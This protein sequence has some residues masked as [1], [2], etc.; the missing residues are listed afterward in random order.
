MRKSNKNESLLKV[1]TS[2]TG[3]KLVSHNQAWN[4]IYI[5]L[6][7]KSV[8]LSMTRHFHITAATCG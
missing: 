1:N 5:D 3:C 2:S 7:A 6:Q 4:L 8:V